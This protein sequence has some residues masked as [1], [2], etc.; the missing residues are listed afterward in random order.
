[1]TSPKTFPLTSFHW[2]TYRA[3]LDGQGKLSKLHDFEHDDDPSPIGAGIVDVLDGPTRITQ[4]MVRKGWME[5]G[6]QAGDT[7]RGE[8]SFVPVSW[9]TAIDLVAREL[10]RVK[11]N[12]SNEAIY[13]GSYGWA[14]AGRFH[15][16]QGQLKRFMNGMGGF[17]RSVNSYSLAAGEV[18][19]DHVLGNYNEMI[20]RQTSW[21]SIIDDTEL[22]VAFGG[23]PLKNGQIGQGGVGRHRQAEAM[24]QARD[25]GV[26][27]VNVSPIRADVTGDLDADWIALRPGSDVAF[28]LGLAHTLVSKNLHA[29]DFLE[30]CTVGFDQF[31]AYLLGENDGQPKS[32]AWAAEKSGIPAQ[33]IIDLAH[34]MC[35]KRTM[36]SASWSLTR[37][38]HGEQ[39]FWMLI[40]LAAMVGQIGLS[41]GGFGLGYSAVNN[42]G[43]EGKDIKLAAMSQGHNPVD[44]FIPVARISDMLLNPGTEFSYNGAQYSYPDIKLIYWAGGNP[45]HHHQDLNRLRKAWA[46]PETIIAHEWCWNSHAK[47]ADIVLPCTTPPEREDLLLNPRDPYQIW[48]QKVVEPPKGVLDDFEI[49]R[50]L[51]AKLGF[52]E[53]FTEGRTQQEW[54][55]V[56]QDRSRAMNTDLE[57]PMFKLS[58]LKDAEYQHI[59]PPQDAFIMLADYR[60]NPEAHPL[61]TPSGKI[62]IGS[63]TIAG[64]NLTDCYGHPAWFE[65]QEWL[66]GDT[67]RHPLHILSNQPKTKLHSQLDH[68]SYSRQHKISEREPLTMHPD[69]AA[70]RGVQSGDVV[71]VHNDRGACL[72]GVIV[73]SEVMPGVVQLSTGAWYDPEKGADGNAMCKHGNPNVLTLDR[74]TS[75]LAQGPIAHSCLVE[76]SLFTDTPPKVTAHQPP[77]ICAVNKRPDS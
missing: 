73:S 65:P 5:N 25:A 2:G 12:Y 15:H 32:A 75:T 9:D 53:A 55:E 54:L 36:L 28:M 37:Q 77:E 64:Y 61:K 68:G 11:K 59:A 50:M 31:H 26:K 3:E 74:G 29:R 66:G 7:P 70:R 51:A 30:R 4:P 22:F 35:S 45:F 16:A 24:Q 10:Q 63:R 76:V 69:D 6:P 58:E 38:E 47:H 49:F 17:V 48:M 56:L 23:L 27:F 33:Q 67:S 34:Q 20:Y 72:C 42:I 71:K 44:S 39:P 62:E 14:S 19:V 21:Q 52:E 18:I 41:G 40:T 43:L 60:R 8:D 57:E 13:A 1:M 46:K